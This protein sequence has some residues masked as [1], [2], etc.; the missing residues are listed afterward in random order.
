MQN[1]QSENLS[2]AIAVFRDNIDHQ[3][4]DLSYLFL[5]FEENFFYLS[6]YYSLVIFFFLYFLIYKY[7]LYPQ[8]Q[9]S[10]HYYISR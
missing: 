4:N 3:R 7:P 6:Y 10:M 1:T 2:Q 8:Q 9:V 5:Q